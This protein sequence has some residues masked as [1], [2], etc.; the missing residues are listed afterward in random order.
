MISLTKKLYKCTDCGS[1]KSHISVISDNRKILVEFLPEHIEDASNI[2]EN[3]LYGYTVERNE[4]GIILYK[5]V[6]KF[7]CDSCG[8]KNIES[9][10]DVVWE[11]V[12][13]FYPPCE[14]EKWYN[15]MN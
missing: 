13:N 11:N 4:D 12:L 7:Y 9:Y 1:K 14:A 15:A 8:S 2:S 5:K 10:V 6:H 3:G